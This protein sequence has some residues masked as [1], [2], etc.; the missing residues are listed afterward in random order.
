MNKFPL[1]DIQLKVNTGIFFKKSPA[2]LTNAT[3]TNTSFRFFPTQFHKIIFI[4]KSV[5][6]PSLTAK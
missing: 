5:S 6:K 1:Q 3:T 4:V 2:V